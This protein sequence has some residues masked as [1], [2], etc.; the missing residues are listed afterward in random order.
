MRGFIAAVHLCT[1][2]YIGALM[3]RPAPVV[4]APVKVASWIKT[5]KLQDQVV[6]PPWPK[7]VQ[8]ETIQ[9]PEPQRPRWACTLMRRAVDRFSRDEVRRFLRGEGHNKFEIDDAMACLTEK[10]T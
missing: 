10:K 3:Y 5:D 2:L 7:V 6:N 1:A 9:K 4:A 8:V